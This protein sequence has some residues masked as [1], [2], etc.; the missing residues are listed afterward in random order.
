MHNVKWSSAAR[1]Q[2]YIEIQSAGKQI[3]NCS[4]DSDSGDRPAGLSFLLGAAKPPNATLAYAK[5]NLIH[6]YSGFDLISEDTSESVGQ[7]WA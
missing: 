5:S 2:F 3:S 7:E 6:L 4:C 1:A